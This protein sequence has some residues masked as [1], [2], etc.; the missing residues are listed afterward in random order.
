MCLKADGRLKAQ[1]SLMSGCG[2]RRLV[3]II[4]QCRA[5]PIRMMC[6]GASGRPRAKERRRSGITGRTRT[7]I[8]SGVGQ[9]RDRPGRCEPKG[10]K[11]MI[12]SAEGAK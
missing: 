6:S 5:A 10:I 7:G 1:K 4:G 9:A 8:R 11:N 2:F 12:P 3:Y